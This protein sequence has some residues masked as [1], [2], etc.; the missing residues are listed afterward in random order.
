MAMDPAANVTST[1]AVLTPARLRQHLKRRLPDVLTEVLLPAIRWRVNNRQLVA[2]A[3]NPTWEEVLRQQAGEVLTSLAAE[4]GLE[5]RLGSIAQNGDM[6]DQGGTI[7]EVLKDPGRE[8]ALSACRQVIEAPGAVHNPLYL[9]GPSGSGKSHLLHAMA[10]SFRELLPDDQVVEIA[11][12]H[13]VDRLARELAEDKTGDLQNRFDE[14]VVIFLDGIEAVAGRELAQ[15]QLFHLINA[16]LEAGQQLVISG[17]AAPRHLVDIEDRLSTRLGWGLSV[18]LDLPLLDSRL[19]LLRQL[20]GDIADDYP[21]S[22]LATWTN[23]LA[24]DLHQVLILA[25]RLRRG[26]RPGGLRSAS[27][28]RVLELVAARFDLRAGDIAGKRRHRQVAL[29]RQTVLLLCRRLT[30][31]SLDSLGAMVGGRD[32]S[33]VL[34]SIRQAEERAAEDQDYARLLADLSQSLLADGAGRQR[35]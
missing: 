31:H 29:A 4:R 22:E 23:S 9:F 32:H 24:P 30:N 12:S 16:A 15:E 5:L 3:I 28:D 26:E 20:L 14:A 18:A 2:L 21:A 17:Q 25:E 27:F 8:F 35:R 33:T 10:H 1:A 6:T 7:D 11:M 34:Y 13:W 19:A